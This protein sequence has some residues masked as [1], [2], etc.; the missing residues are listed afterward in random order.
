MFRI[1]AQSRHSDLVYRTAV[2]LTSHL[3]ATSHEWRRR[4]ATSVP[5]E[6]RIR[7]L[8]R[9]NLVVSIGIE[10]CGPDSSIRTEAVV[11]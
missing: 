7:T 10:R 5:E 2:I 6:A 11:C 3:G 1:A 9:Q 4:V 8:L